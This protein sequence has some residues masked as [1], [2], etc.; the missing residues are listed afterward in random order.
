MLLYMG[1]C[2]CHGRVVSCCCCWRT[3]MVIRIMMLML[4][5]LSSV[6]LWRLSGM[7]S[8]T[9]MTMRRTGL[10]G[11]STI[12]IHPIHHGRRR[13]VMSRWGR[14]RPSGW[15]RRHMLRGRTP[16][17][18]RGKWLPLLKRHMSRHLMVSRHLMHRTSSLLRRWWRRPIIP[19]LVHHVWRR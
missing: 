5:R 3:I 7:E 2:G 1:V 14:L 8:L 16:S 11:A 9:R 17:R 4:R 18:S 13:V 12:H 19:L 15:W 6:M 10:W